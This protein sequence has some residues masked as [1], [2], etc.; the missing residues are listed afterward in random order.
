MTY[1]FFVHDPD[2]NVEKFRTQQEAIDKANSLIEFYR[3]NSADDGWDELVGQIF[4]GE[5]KQTAEMVNKE[6]APEGSSFDYSCDYALT[7]V[8]PDQPGS[9]PDPIIGDWKIRRLGTGEILVWNNDVGA[10][11][12]TDNAEN[13]ASTI[14]HGLASELIASVAGGHTLAPATDGWQ[15]VPIKPTEEMLDV[16]IEQSRSIYEPGC[17]AYLENPAEV[18]MAMLAAS[19]K[20]EGGAA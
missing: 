17:G 18:Y 6:P 11:R 2:G 10:Y 9:G 4:W 7:D 12:A 19:P 20:L 8:S 3:E 14:L 13:I 1:R 5:I 16:A 15:P